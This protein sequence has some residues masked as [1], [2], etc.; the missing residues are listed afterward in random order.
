MIKLDDILQSLSES[1]TAPTNA[2]NQPGLY[3]IYGSADVWQEL[4]LGD[5][6][7][8]RPLYV[9]KAEKSLLGRDVKQHFGTGA[10]GSSTVRRSFAALL[11]AQHNFTGIPRNPKKSG[12]FSNYGLPLEQCE[13]LTRWMRERLLLG[14][15]APHEE[16]NL[17]D[18]ETQV[19]Q[20]WKPPIN[21]SK[22]KTPWS[23]RLKEL[24]KIL[25]DEARGYVGTGR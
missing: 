16:V 5:P 1:R 7:D 9:G 18:W 13:K 3:A 8:D 24:R 25:A 23:K 11:K 12:H 15:W 20:V 2:P 14:T 6:P 17:D 21:L 19:L 10:T 22:V 4:G